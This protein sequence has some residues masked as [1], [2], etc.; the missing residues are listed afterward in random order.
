MSGR[1]T[2][3]YYSFLVLP[4]EKRRAILAVWDFCR[5]VDD[6]VDEAPEGD[7]PGG[8]TIAAARVAAWRRELGA[9]YGEGTPATTQGHR[10]A[11]II[12]RFGLPR[13]AF[14]HV[15]DGV[16][17]DLERSRY[18]TFEDLREYCLRVAS[19]VG[20]ICLEIFGYRN[21][22]SRDYG[23]DLGIALQLTNIVRDVRSDLAR[24]R[25]YLPLE[26]LR[27][28][29]C[30]EDDL[31]AGVVTPAVRALL[32]FECERAQAHYERAEREL[33]A[34]DRRAMVA[35]RIMGGIYHAILRRI[36]RS[37]YDVF[38]GKVRVPRPQ[39]AAIA[40]A[41]WAKAMVGL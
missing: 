7:G 16:A 26:D 37:G 22:R 20:L 10:L 35:A 17:M 12:G 25:V 27:K 15:I 9:C 31:A 32:A 28:F 11:P 3:F 21:P 23:V 18:E 38:Q 40:A 33:P 30:R 14:E 19:A 36:E 8:G 4:A 5:A 24:G 29:G 41:I 39:R 13:D 1:D 34:E 2:S 6:A